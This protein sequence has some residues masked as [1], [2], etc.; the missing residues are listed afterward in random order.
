[1][2]DGRRDEE[3]GKRLQRKVERKAGLNNK[4]VLIS[5]CNKESKTLGP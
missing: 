1:M 5:V 4:P 3:G 2:S